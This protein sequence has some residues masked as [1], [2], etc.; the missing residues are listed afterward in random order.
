MV[1]E[2]QFGKKEFVEAIRQFQRVMYGYGGDNASDGVKNWQAKSAFE[3]A[4]CAE[5]QI[6]DASGAARTKLIEE[7][8]KAYQFAIAKQPDGELATKAAERLK[9][10]AAL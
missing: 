6:A 4:R 1:G 7:A 9:A 2:L 8:K 3:A 5:V 10:L